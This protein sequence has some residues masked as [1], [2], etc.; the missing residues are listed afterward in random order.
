[1]PPRKQ[2]V[3]GAALVVEVPQRI[4]GVRGREEPGDRRVGGRVLGDEEISQLVAEVSQRRPIV[5]AQPDLVPGAGAS[6]GPAERH[7]RVP[8]A[9]WPTGR[10]RGGA[11]RRTRPSRAGR[12]RPRP[13]P[14]CAR[15]SSASPPSPADTRRASGTPTSRTT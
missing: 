13:C 14:S 6:D 9:S 5:V 1:E 10:E 11:R 12:S 7:V 4:L 3:A 15:P 2:L 8:S